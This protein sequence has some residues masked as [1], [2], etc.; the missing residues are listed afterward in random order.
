[1]AEKFSPRFD[2]RK[3][4]PQSLLQT[5]KE[6]EKDALDPEPK[7]Q[8][9][10]PVDQIQHLAICPVTSHGHRATWPR[11][12]PSKSEK[13]TLLTQSLNLR[14]PPLWIKSNILPSAQSLRMDI[15]RLGQDFKLPARSPYVLAPQPQNFQNSKFARV[16]AEHP[17]RP[18]SSMEERAVLRKIYP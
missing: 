12:Q 14:M 3:I 8:N 4:E 18:S 7:P 10:T 17:A 11:F 15:V 6:R 2:A 13:R 16:D 9:A 1:M 5:L